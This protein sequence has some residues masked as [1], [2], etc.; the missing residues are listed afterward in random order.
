MNLHR[1]YL[2]TVFLL[3]MIEILCPGKHLRDPS[4]TKLI[5]KKPQFISI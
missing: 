2:E 3:V 4:E 5:L 1:N